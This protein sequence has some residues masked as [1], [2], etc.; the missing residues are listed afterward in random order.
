MQL[1]GVSLSVVRVEFA[2]ECTLV[3]ELKDAA[4]KATG[5]LIPSEGFIEVIHQGIK[6]AE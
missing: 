6:T 2:C 3:A 1:P 4:T 5:L